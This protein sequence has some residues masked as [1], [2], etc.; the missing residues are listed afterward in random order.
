MKNVSSVVLAT[1][2]A[3]NANANPFE[4]FDIVD[5]THAFDANTI[6]WPTEKD[7]KHT[8]SFAGETEG[9]WYYSAFSV[10]TAEHGGTH[11]DAPIHFAE[12]RWSADQIPTANLFSAAV[13][14]DV[15]AKAASNPDYQL[16]VDDILAWEQQHGEIPKG[17]TVLMNTGFS[18][19]WPDRLEYLGTAERGPEAVRSLHFPGFSKASA[20]F[21][22]HERDITAV[23]LDTASI[24]YGQSTDF[25]VHR[26]LY[27]QNILGFENVANLDALPPVGAWLIALPMKIANGSGA[28]LRIVGLVPASR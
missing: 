21:L 11:L 2:L 8:E 5:L 9:G 28:P 3:V 20:E 22:A 10:Q 15:K 4:G 19:R 25:I 16:S 12:G 13:V 1:L 17:A 23:G 27:E 6:Y 18:M 24:D 26:L 14:I 7:F